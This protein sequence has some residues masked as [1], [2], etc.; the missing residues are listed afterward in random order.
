[1]KVIGVLAI[2]AGI[3]LGI[4]FHSG[5]VSADITNKGEAQVRVYRSN[6]ADIIKGEK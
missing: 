3:G 4:A 2:I 6:L 5:W 1:M